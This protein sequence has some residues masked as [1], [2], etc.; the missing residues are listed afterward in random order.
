[1]RTPLGRTVF[2]AWLTLLAVA[3]ASAPAAQPTTQQLRENPELLRSAY[4]LRDHS[5]S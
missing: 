2:V 1:M 3:C 5:T 4:L